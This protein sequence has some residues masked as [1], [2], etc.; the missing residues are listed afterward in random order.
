ME[1]TKSELGLIH[2]LINV[3]WQT[4]TVK[5]PQMAQGVEQLRA[6]IIQRIEATEKPKLEPVKKEKAS[7]PN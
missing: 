5:S 2:D 4:G 7:G 3:A 1:F 6:K